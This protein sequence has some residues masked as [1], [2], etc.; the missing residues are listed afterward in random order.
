MVIVEFRVQRGSQMIKPPLP[1]RLST[2]DWVRMPKP[3]E[4]LC[5]LSRTT[6]FELISSGDIKSAVVRKRGSQKGIRLIFRPSLL[7][8][9]ETC[10]EAPRDNPLPARNRSG[11]D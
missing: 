8:H 1:P 5:G 10:V 6:L 4:R 3:R 11:N 9:L 7:A 2:D